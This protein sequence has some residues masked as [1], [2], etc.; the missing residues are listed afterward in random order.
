MAYIIIFMYVCKYI[1]IHIVYVYYVSSFNYLEDYINAT[2]SCI[3]I[4]IF[5]YKSAQ[6]KTYCG[7][8]FNLMSYF[9]KKI[10]SD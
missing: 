1:H 4:D 6:I 9:L 8:N 7:R 2:K 3:Q 5:K 10:N